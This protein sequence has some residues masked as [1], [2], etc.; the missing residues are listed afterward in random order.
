MLERELANVRGQI[1]R[2]QGRK[3]SLEH[4]TSVSTIAISLHVP[5]VEPKLTNPVWDPVK[6][7]ERGFH[8]SLVAL[9][10]LADVVISLVSFL[11]WAIPFSALGFYLYWRGRQRRPVTPP[12]APPP[13][14]E[15]V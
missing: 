1:E 4:Q 12:P 5:P 9:E 2:I 15:S 14:V 11:W 6:S 3:R 8:A 10:T 7:F 13:A